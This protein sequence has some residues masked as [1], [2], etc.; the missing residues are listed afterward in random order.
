MLRVTRA[1]ERA[2]R[3]VGDARRRHTEL[4]DVAYHLRRPL[5]ERE[6]ARLPRRAADP[7]FPIE[8]ARP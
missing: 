5:T 6:A 4:G 8:Q 7:T 3:G 1:A 2:L